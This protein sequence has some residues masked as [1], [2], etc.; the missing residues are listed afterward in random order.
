MTDRIPTPTTDH[1]TTPFTFGTAHRGAPERPRGNILHLAAATAV[2]A[3]TAALCGATPAHAVLGGVEEEQ[4]ERFLRRRVDTSGG[5][6]AWTWETMIRSCTNTLMLGSPEQDPEQSQVRFTPDAERFLR[7]CATVKGFRELAPGEEPSYA[8]LTAA[9]AKR[10]RVV[11]AI[12]SEWLNDTSRSGVSKERRNRECA[13]WAGLQ[14]EW[15]A[16]EAKGAGVTADTTALLLACAM[17]KGFDIRA[18]KA[19]APL[20]ALNDAAKAEMDAAKKR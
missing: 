20:K 7:R 3:L 11:D 17:N 14:P 13:G 9:E 5:D 4:V 19:G 6:G 16:M 1:R 18:E 8:P 10:I 2:V 12:L 15:R